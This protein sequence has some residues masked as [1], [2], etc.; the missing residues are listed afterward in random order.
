MEQTSKV[1]CNSFYTCNNILLK[2]INTRSILASG[3]ADCSVA[4]WDLSQVKCVMVIPHPDKVI[5]TTI[6][7]YK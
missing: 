2:F 5:K 1:S 3:S 7:M 6:D 4:V